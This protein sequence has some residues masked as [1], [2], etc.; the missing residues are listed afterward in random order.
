MRWIEQD[1]RHLMAL[2]AGG[3][4]A[5]ALFLLMHAFI[6]TPPMA[7]TESAPAMPIG[8]VSVHH[9]TPV[10]R[11][12]HHLSKPKPVKRPPTTGSVPKTPFKPIPR[13]RLPLDPRSFDPGGRGPI[14]T[15][16]PQ[17]PG[18]G[19]GGASLSVLVRIPPLYPPQAAYGNVTGTVTTCFT[20]R[21][22]GSVANAR[23]TAAS[24]AQARRLL[25]PAALAS[26]VQ[27]KFVPRTADGH[28]AATKDVCQDI[29]FALN[30]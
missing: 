8:W 4:V 28:A 18:T 14:I 29:A 23:I 20:V 13:Q 24:S 22:D 12:Q 30:R 3:A 6:A 19:P 7:A 17:S 9:E 2:A 16:G 10:Q 5:F 25:G 21:S 15:V 1:L 26:I 27:W 11:K